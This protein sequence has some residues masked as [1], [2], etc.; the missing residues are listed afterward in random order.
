MTMIRRSLAEIR[1]TGT[2]AARGAG[3]PW[4]LAE[5]AGM[6]ARVLESFDLPGIATLARV[7]RSGRCCE[8]AN[9]ARPCAIKTLAALSDSPP[10]QPLQVGPTI[11][12]LF[13]LAGV[14][15]HATPDRGWRLNWTGGAITCGAGGIAMEG[16]PP[17]DGSLNVTISPIAPRDTP[18]SQSWDSR[19]ISADTWRF[20]ETLAARTYVPNSA[21]SQSKGAGPDTADT[22]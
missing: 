4:G 18:V 2:K 12:P 7:L 13:L 20:L 1:A 5:E 22:E 14:L 16:P 17:P 8:C 19:E 10:S 11:A 6:A 15:P 3:C 21:E 9:G